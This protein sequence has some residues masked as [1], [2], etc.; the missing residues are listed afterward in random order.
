MQRILFSAYNA[1]KGKGSSVDAGRQFARWL[2]EH[3]GKPG[4]VTFVG[5]TEVW[6]PVGPWLRGNDEQTRRL[7][8]IGELMRRDCKLFIRSLRP[9]LIEDGYQPETLDRWIGDTVRELDTL[10]VHMYCTWH[11]AWGEKAPE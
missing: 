10:S 5:E 4:G 11:Y 7:N 6:V 8:Y 1:L 2:G 3:V 9:L